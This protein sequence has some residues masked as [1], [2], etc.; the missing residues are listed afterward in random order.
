MET[1]GW[2]RDEERPTLMLETDKV[3][4]KVEF[5][6]MGYEDDMANTMF[7]V[8]YDDSR[9]V[10]RRPEPMLVTFLR[11][12]LKAEE[13]ELWLNDSSPEV[14]KLDDEQLASIEE[15]MNRLKDVMADSPLGQ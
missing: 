12:L 5:E 3:G 4:S 6:A 13:Y 8:T 9:M 1:F 11:L 7:L 15:T 2:D 10:V 14:I